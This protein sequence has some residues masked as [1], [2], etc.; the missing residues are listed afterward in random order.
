MER[1]E[2]F[3]F[4]WKHGLVGKQKIKTTC[5]KRLEIIDPGIQNFHAG[6][7]FFNAKIRIGQL[8][9]AGNVEI[10]LNASDWIK[11]KHHT[12]PAYDNVILHVVT[13]F[14]ETIWNSLGRIIPTLIIDIPDHIISHYNSLR[15]DDSWMPCNLYI[16][17][18]PT[19][20]MQ[21]WFKQLNAER[22][23]QKTDRI[24]KIL[25]LPGM[26]NEET[27]YRALASGYGLPINTLPF[28]LATS[29]IPLT[30]LLELRDNLQVLEALLFGQ[31]GF[32][33]PELK[34]SPYAIK[35]LDLFREREK[36][37][38]SGGGKGRRFG[39]GE[40]TRSRILGQS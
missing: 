10:H 35:L 34:E 6:P 40:A 5:G 25:S 30:L 22:L 36:F 32:L 1:E 15:I 14:D 28:E 8:V 27:F 33:Y 17:N 13:K 18:V 26:G 3:Q 4:V 11:H 16:R 23:H 24:S 37:P 39:Y 20:H 31:S 19:L 7:D 2:F 38:P 21:H 29:G 9:W 12:N